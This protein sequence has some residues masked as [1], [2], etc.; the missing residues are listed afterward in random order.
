MR[1]PRI[2]FFRGLAIY[3]IFVDHVD[4][5]P[6]AKI[7]YHMLGFSD[8]AE[9]FVF[10]SGLAC[11]IA[12]ARIVKR[13]G[14]SALI[15]AITRRSW[16]IYLYYA[17]SSIAMILLVTIAV[18][19]YGVQET[20]GISTEHPFTAILLA[21][22]LISSPQLSGILVIYIALTLIVVPALLIAYPRH[23][24][25]ALA[26][27][28]LIWVGAQVFSAAMA[29][30]T[31]RLYL[32]PLA[33]QFLFAIGMTLGMRREARQP[34]LALPSQ[35][36][37]LV[38]A[39]WT[40]VIGALIYRVLAA[41]Y[42]FNMTSLRLEQS[43]LDWMKEN[44]SPIRLMHFLSIALL[45][46]VYIPQDSAFLKWPIFKPLIKTGMHSL[47]VFS[48]SI[49]LTIVVNIVVLTKAPSLGDRLA[50]DSIAILVMILAATAIAYRRQI[51]VRQEV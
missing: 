28:G 25:L 38:V 20:F 34:M 32:N 14:F 10:I 43:T 47:E 36:R 37:W 12:Y 50:I 31:H 44:L 39:A 42:G 29:P 45:V 15:A 1:D 16:R 4:G 2:D 33:W 3:M 7:T 41:R 22:S 17:L 11:G 26:I 6:L 35:R 49:V 24:G 21:L 27:S 51:A 23:Q 40:V 18:R 48:L 5:D 46:S 8:A 30:L 9:I 13:R 19:H